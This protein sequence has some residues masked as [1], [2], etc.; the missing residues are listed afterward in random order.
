MS[1]FSCKRLDNVPLTYIG[2]IGIAA[3]LAISFLVWLLMVPRWANSEKGHV[4]HGPEVQFM[5]LYDAFKTDVTLAEG[6]MMS[7]YLEPISKRLHGGIGHLL[8]SAD[9][10]NGFQLGDALTDEQVMI[11]FD[12]DFANAL[13]GASHYFPDFREFP[14]LVQLAILNWLW[15]LGASAPEA[16]PRATAALHARDWGTAAQEW[17]YADRHHRRWSRWRL[18]TQHRCEQEAERLQHVA[19]L[20]ASPK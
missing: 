8:T 9:F 6:R 7:V 15:Q 16:F 10:A 17:L 12:A 4:S 2:V 5:N 18:E 1:E 11:W 20:E 19:E 14:R 13:K 3:V